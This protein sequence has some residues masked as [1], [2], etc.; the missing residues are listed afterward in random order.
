MAAFGGALDTTADAL[1]IPADPEEA[2]VNNLILLVKQ[3]LDDPDCA[4]LTERSRMWCT[5]FAVARRYL[6]VGDAVPSNNVAFMER[7]ARWREE[8]RVD[9]MEEDEALCVY[10]CSLRS[11]MLYELSNTSSGRPLLIERVGAWDVTALKTAAAESP[12]QIVFAHVLVNER[13]RRQLDAS[14]EEPLQTV[15]VFDCAGLSWAHLRAATLMG[16]FSTMSQLDAAHFP[17]CMGTI[18]VV[19]TGWAFVKLW[20]V[21][22][23]F[24]AEGTCAK[25]RIFSTAEGEAMRAALRETCGADALPAELGGTRRCAPPYSYTATVE[26]SDDSGASGR[27]PAPREDGQA[28]DADELVVA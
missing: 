5:S 19:N 16:L 6:R 22:S 21:A 4:P 2:R 24:V 20:S 3:K 11:I 13:I 1:N 15:L 10:E 9:D 23:R 28:D 7:T 27:T 26:H 25:V 12:E 18:F 17:N 8:Q 14:R